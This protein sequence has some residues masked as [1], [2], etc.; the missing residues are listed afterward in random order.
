VQDGLLR[1]ILGSPEQATI[2]AGYSKTFNQ[3]RFDRFTANAGNNPG[4][5]T[6][7]TR[8]TTAYCLVCPGESWPLLFRERDRLGPPDFP[9]APVYPISATTANNLNMFQADLKQPRVHSWSAGIQR[10]IGSDM[11]IEVRYVG[12]KNMYAWAEENWNERVL[13]ENGFFDEWKL[14][15]ANLYANIAAGR[16]ATFA[17]TGIPGTSPLPIHQAYLSGR[18]GCRRDHPGPLHR[19]PVLQPDVPRAV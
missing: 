1:T 5:T 14:A 7:A 9:E 3:E 15:Q 12:N 8:S 10:S 11:A 17:Y 16:G 6:S 19:Q 18:S 4:G 2:R 13:F